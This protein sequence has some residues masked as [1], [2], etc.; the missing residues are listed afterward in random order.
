MPIYP[1]HPFPHLLQRSELY[2]NIFPN[3]MYFFTV[4]D[5]APNLNPMKSQVVFFDFFSFFFIY[6]LN[7]FLLIEI[8]FVSQNNTLKNNHIKILK[9]IL[10]K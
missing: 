9:K 6:K 1:A 4:N 7:F 5:F 10:V 2:F 3:N 8:I